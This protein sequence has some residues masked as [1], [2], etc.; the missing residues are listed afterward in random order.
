MNIYKRKAGQTGQSVVE[1][2]IGTLIFTTVATV[3]LSLYSIN[4]MELSKFWNKSDVLT[5]ATDGIARLGLLIRSA[6]GFGDNYGVVQSNGDVLIDF[7]KMLNGNKIAGINTNATAGGL[8]NGSQFLISPTFPS[9]GDPYYGTGNLPGSIYGGTWPMQSSPQLAAPSGPGQ[10]AA[11]GQYTLSQDCL[12]V[13]VP[14]FV[15]CPP[16]GGGIGLD[17]FDDQAK[18]GGAQAPYVWPATFDGNQSAQAA[19]Q[20]V[21]TYVFKV[22][23]DPNAPGTFMLQ[24]AAF[25]ACPAGGANPYG[26][27][28]TGHPTNVYL[29]T[30]APVTVVR[31]IVGPLDLAGNISI[32]SYVEK[33]NNT[34]TNTP[35]DATHMLTDYNGVIINMEVLKTQSGSKAAVGSFKTEFFLRNNSQVTLQ[36]PP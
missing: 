31:G 19:L 29:S 3:M 14:V 2:L 13:Q 28:Y 15:G 7:T 6:R 24:E 27:A 22:M 35:P 36:G 5:S 9:A 20:A 25:P 1:L 32:F 11:P 30:T 21:D 18:N 8:L 23:P 10:P 12:I 17:P 4:T 16:G 33:V 26:G 34:T